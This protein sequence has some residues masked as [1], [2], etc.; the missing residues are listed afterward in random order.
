MSRIISN[1]GEI[2]NLSKNTIVAKI[3]YI[4]INDTKIN[5]FK[6]IKSNIIEHK[7]G[8][9]EIITIEELDIEYVDRNFKSDNV[10][11]IRLNESL[12]NEDLYCNKI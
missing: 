4:E 5:I 8:N 12:I 11:S 9:N 7:Y 1:S 6:N 2:I 10:F 3:D